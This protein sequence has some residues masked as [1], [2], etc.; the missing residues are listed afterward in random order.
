MSRRSVCL[1]RF[2]ALIVLSAMTAFLAGSTPA[3]QVLAQNKDE[4]KAVVVEEAIEAIPAVIVVPA[5]PAVAVA[6]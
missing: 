6:V 3:R 4:P 1:G 2:A 5:L